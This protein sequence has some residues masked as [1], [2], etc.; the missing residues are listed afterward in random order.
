MIINLENISQPMNVALTGTPGTG[1]STVSKL[2]RD[3]GY[4]VLD[5][6]EIALTQKLTKSFDD[7][8]Q[9]T[10]VDLGKINEYLEQHYK[11]STK[12][13]VKDKPIFLESHFAHLLTGL[14][15]VIV[16]R[17]HPEALK[18]R[19]RSRDWSEKKLRENLEAEAVD[20]I[21]IESVTEHGQGMTF[22][23][24]TTSKKPDLVKE[25]I[26]AIVAGN[27][28]KFKVGQIDWSEEILKWY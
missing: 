28:E 24:D 27:N 16:L 13:N 21:T 4:T 22:E 12:K 7:H 6:N 20:T 1:K 19:L 15:L 3:D 18:K 10:E 17:C 9:T 23:I 14:E 8:R 2:L 11:D 25:N 5:L 26:L